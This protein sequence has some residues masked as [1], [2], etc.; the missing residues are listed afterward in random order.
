MA[1]ASESVAIGYL[2]A[3]EEPSARGAGV[4]GSKAASLA[5]ALGHGLPVVPGFVITTRAHAAYLDAGRT[6]PPELTEPLHE[7]WGRFTDGGRTPVA[8]RSSSTVEDISSGSMAGRFRSVLDVQG[9]DDFLAAVEDVWGSADEVGHGSPS[10]MGVLVQRHLSPRKSG[11][12]FGV[13]PVTGDRTTVVVEAVSGGPDKLVSGQVTAEHYVLTRRGRP[14]ALDYRSYFRVRRHEERRRLLGPADFV[15]LS[16]LARKTERV[17]GA[18]QDV[19]WAT[20]DD[21]VLRLLQSRPVTAT[22]AAAPTRGPVLGPGPL[23]ETFPDPL[24]ELEVDLWVR[25]LRAGVVDAMQETGAV[26][27]ARVA[28]SPV[29]T[30]VNGRV[31]V[32][33]EL[34]GY[35]RTRSPLGPLDPRPGARQL[36]AA[37]RTGSLRAELPARVTALV[38]ETDRWL[39]GIDPTAATEA[40]LVSLLEQAVEVLRRLHHDEALAGTLLPAAR[41]TGAALALRIL[42]SADSQPPADELVRGHPVLLTLTPPSLQGRLV[43]PP[44]AAAGTP[45][46][47]PE[48]SEP[49]GP[50]EQLRLRARW[51]QELTVRVAIDLGRR[52][53]LR[54]LLEHHTEIGLL[55]LEEVGALV[56]GAQPAPGLAERRAGEVMAAFSPPLP[57]EFRL[58]DSH[59]VVPVRRP[60]GSPGFGTPAGGGRGLGAVCHGSVRRPP[61]PGEV[62][63]VRTLEPGLAGWLPELAGLVA[64]TGASLSHL[65]ILAREYGVPTVVGVHDALRRFPPGTRLLVDG[66]TGEVRAVG[67]EEES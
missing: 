8:V 42:T 14:V 56:A 64:E 3:L 15:A 61:S 16:A 17:F 30:T 35:V 33:L 41:A 36:K 20:G 32:D 49:L 40:E 67:G 60:R 11:V 50:R 34:F 55:R 29:V 25:P 47:S 4:T 27:A 6:L 9:W 38:E 45:P 2:C 57:A 13:D 31:A 52:L 59:E 48:P 43:L 28:G 53:K 24:G 22:A 58:T 62:L 65:A 10:P 23:G 46:G 26:P 37:W 12:M 54:G 21:E 7:V 18:P 51:V 39:T 66:G 5:Q 19:E 1:V 44:V 63:V